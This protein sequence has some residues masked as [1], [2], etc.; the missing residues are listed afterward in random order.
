[1]THKVFAI[2]DEKAENY[3]RPIFLPNDGLAIRSFSDS[4]QEQGSVIARHPADYRLHLLGEYDDRTGSFKSLSNPKFLAVASDFVNKVNG[5][6][7]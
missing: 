1:M 3:G 2:Y 5:K 4:I 6:E 7:S